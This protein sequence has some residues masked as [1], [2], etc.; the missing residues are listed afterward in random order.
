M[1]IVHMSTLSIEDGKFYLVSMMKDVDTGQTI[2]K[3]RGLTDLM[4]LSILKAE[5]GT[6]TL[7]A[8]AS[9]YLK[10]KYKNG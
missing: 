5:S 2:H 8:R 7:S 10:G 6:T 1:K 4:A 3:K 9:R